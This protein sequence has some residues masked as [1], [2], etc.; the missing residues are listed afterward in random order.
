MSVPS[1]EKWS[2]EIRWF[3]RA[4]VTTPSKKSRAT[5]AFRIRSLFFANVDASKLGSDMSMSRNQRNS[6]L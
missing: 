5:S 1:T 6:R 3:R 2:G 4:V